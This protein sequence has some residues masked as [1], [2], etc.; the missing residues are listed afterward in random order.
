MSTMHLMLVL[1]LSAFLACDDGPPAP[2]TDPGTNI[3]LTVTPAVQWSGGT[4]TASSEA[5]PEGSYAFVLDGDTL[6]AMPTADNA[7]EVVLPNPRVTGPA[8]LELHIDGVVVANADVEIVGASRAPLRVE[9]DPTLSAPFCTPQLEGDAPLSYHGV[10][11]PDGRLLAFVR[12]IGGEAGG[13]RVGYGVARLNDPIPTFEVPPRLELNPPHAGF[14]GL[15]APGPTTQP[16]HWLLESSPEDAT[17]PPARWA[18]TVAGGSP[19]PLDCVDAGLEGGY[20]I[21]ETASGAC[22]VL[23]HAPFDGFAQLTI[24]G[25]DPVPG[26][27]EIPYDWRGGCSGFR[28]ATDGDWTTLRSLNGLFF[29]DPSDDQ[30]PPAWPV[31]ASDGSLAFTSDRYPRWPKDAEFTPDGVLWAIGET[32]TAWSLDAWDPTTGELLDEAA[33]VG[34]ESCWGLRADVLS[35]RLFVACKFAD[36]PPGTDEDWPSLVVYDRAASEIEAV[37]HVPDTGASIV[38]PPFELIHGVAAGMVHLTA[39][40]DGTTSPVDRGVLVASWDVR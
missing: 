23:K 21:S 4:I 33:I 6:E 3:E 25:T 9:C 1:P 36:I 37:L 16:G 24:N 22:L 34:V 39:V 30:Q 20:V 12:L 40:F 5:I 7:V 26:Y 28:S 19:V 13:R 27:Q 2:P 32:S 8:S 17:E 18:F 31:F 38:W 15:L 10:G 29:C 11:L 35:P 14:S